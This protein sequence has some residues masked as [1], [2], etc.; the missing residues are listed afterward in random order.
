MKYHRIQ[1]NLM[2]MWFD[3]KKAFYS[4]PHDW[5]TRALQ[6]AKVQSELIMAVQNLMT[7]WATKQRK[8]QLEVTLS[9]IILQCDCL[10]LNLFVS[11]LNPLSLEILQ[12]TKEEIERIDVKTRKIL[13]LNGSF[14][15][16]SDVDRL[17]SHR[18]S[19]GCRL[20][21]SSDLYISGTISISRHRKEQAN[22][23]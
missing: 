6:L 23:N 17:Y 21:S 12:W 1:L 10:A 20:N 18:K 7:I 14:H 15:V 9:N 22:Q 13:C 3:Y 4:V 19:G 2:M 11:S 5:I 16:N 8:R